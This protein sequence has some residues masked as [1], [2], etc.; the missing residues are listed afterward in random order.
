[1]GWLLI[2]W[3]HTDPL[4]PSVASLPLRLHDQTGKWWRHSRPI[5]TPSPQSSDTAAVLGIYR[6]TVSSQVSRAVSLLGGALADPDERIVVRL[7]CRAIR[8]HRVPTSN[9][10]D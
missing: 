7:A 3:T 2:D 5:S 1:M 4:A 9:L 8:T 10:L 6:N